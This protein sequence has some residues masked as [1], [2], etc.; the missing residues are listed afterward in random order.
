MPNSKKKFRF[1]MNAEL[2]MKKLERAISRLG[3]TDMMQG[4]TKKNDGDIVFNLSFK[5][6]GEPYKF[7]YSKNTA[8]Y[9]GY[10]ISKDSD[11]QNAVIN[12]ISQLAIIAERKIFDFR[13]VFAGFKALEFIELPSWAGFMGFKTVPRTYVTVESKFR[14]LALGA[15]NPERNPDDFMKLTKAL[16]VAKQFYGVKE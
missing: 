2:A 10:A 13:T 1:T 14:E 5:Y 4:T 11:I 12:A 9:Y 8:E 6:E 16:D 15:M 7:S 3:A